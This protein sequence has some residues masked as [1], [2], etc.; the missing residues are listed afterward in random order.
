MAELIFIGVI[1]IILIYLVY[2][3]ESGVRKIQNMV[4]R[5]GENIKI[6]LKHELK[7]RGISDIENKLEK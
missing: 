3:V 1:V 7:S 5:N 4:A 6:I 2:R